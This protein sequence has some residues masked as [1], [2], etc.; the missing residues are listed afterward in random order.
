MTGIVQ[1]LRYA[2]RSLAKN[3]GFAVAAILIA[4]A[5]DWREYRRV[6]CRPQSARAGVAD[7]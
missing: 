4:G 6:Q 5:R 3:P 7:W 2:L 1:D